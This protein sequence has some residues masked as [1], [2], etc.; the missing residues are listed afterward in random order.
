M[1][2]INN[3][4]SYDYIEQSIIKSKKLINKL[5]NNN[6][7]IYNSYN[8]TDIVKFIL[9][10]TISIFIHNV[11]SKNKITLKCINQLT[12]RPN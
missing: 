10:M 4:D 6:I 3:T 11:K 7:K 5:E 1:H 8:L 12:K 9:I 2:I